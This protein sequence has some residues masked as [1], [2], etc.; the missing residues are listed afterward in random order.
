MQVAVRWPSVAAVAGAIALLS[1][2]GV[3]RP[4]QDDTRP[5]VLAQSTTSGDLLYVANKFASEGVSV[6][7]F[8]QGTLVAT[9][10][11]IGRVRGICSDTSGNVWMTASFNRGAGPFH[12]YKFRHG[13][14]RP[15]EA[16]NPHL[17]ASGCAADP[18]IG[19]L[20]V[21]SYGGSSDGVVDVWRGAR[22]GRAA[23]YYTAF[24][25][26]ACAYD[27]KGDLFVDG[28]GDT[29]VALAELVKGGKNFADVALGKN[30]GWSVGS[31][32]WDGTYITL[33]VGTISG[34]SSIYRV[35]VSGEHG[36]IVDMVHLQHLASWPHFVIVNG[37]VVATQRG[38]VV[39]RIGLYEYPGGDKAL[40]VFSG[41]DDPMGMTVSVA[42]K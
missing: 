31:V 35:Q 7:T 38:A 16:R 32:Q 13:G 26:A 3:L 41:F 28:T 33:G 14:T 34:S 37:Q 36:K 11:Q 25:P 1:G 10:E 40:D 24:A 29:G 30:A 42:P 39:R 22:K 19:N 9:I 5:G 4:A 15:V 18:T 12:L 8:P 17:Y 2:C 23:V 21:I 27:D 20:A 6:L